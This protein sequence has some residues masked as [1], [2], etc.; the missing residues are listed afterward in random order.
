MVLGTRWEDIHQKVDIA[1]R[2]RVE[3]FIGLCAEQGELWVS[4]LT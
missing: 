4:L 3:Q 2:A 1:G